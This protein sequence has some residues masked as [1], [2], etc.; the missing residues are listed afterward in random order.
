MKRG[1]LHAFVSSSR[2]SVSEMC[3]C[4]AM[5]CGRMVWPRLRGANRAGLAAAGAPQ[6]AAGEGRR[7]SAPGGGG[8]GGAPCSVAERVCAFSRV[9]SSSSEYNA[10]LRLCLAYVALCQ[11]PRPRLP[12]ALAAWQRGCPLGRPR[13]CRS[14]DGHR[15][16]RRRQLAVLAEER[17]GAVHRG[18]RPVGKKVAQCHAGRGRFW[19]GHSHGLLIR[20]NRQLSS[21]RIACPFRPREPDSVHVQH[22][23]LAALSSSFSSR[24]A[25]AT[26]ARMQGEAGGVD[27]LR[28]KHTVSICPNLKSARASTLAGGHRVACRVAGDLLLPERARLPHR[29]CQAQQQACRTERSRR[30][31]EGD[32]L[33]PSCSTTHGGGGGGGGDGRLQRLRAGRDHFLLTVPA[34]A[35]MC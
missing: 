31:R 1:K 16:R 22:R 4:V 21:T 26:L 29:A 7:D 35:T 10:T 23:E 11:S 18:Y 2:G 32:A 6:A 19:R 30:K 33:G 25:K 14:L 12:L 20:A 34:P 15:E 28:V 9:H 3:V 13:E 5:R 17:R 27:A 24:A 8:G